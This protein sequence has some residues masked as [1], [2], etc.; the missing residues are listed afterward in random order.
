MAI[1]K[2][3][4]LVVIDM[5]RDFVPASIDNPDGGRFGVAEGQDVV[6]PICSMI[7]AASDVGAVILAS[8]DYHPNDHCSFS[9]YG[10][11]FPSHCVAGTSGAKFLPEISEALESAIKKN[12][13]ERV[14]IA[15]KGMHE[16]V[17]SFGALPYASEPFGDGRV[18]KAANAEPEGPGLGNFTKFGAIM[19]CTQA[20]WTGSLVLKQSAI[21]AAAD[22]TDGRGDDGIYDANAPPDVLAVLQDGVDRKLRNMQDAIAANICP[23]KGKIFVC[24][25]ALDFCVHD[26]C[27]NAVALGMER[28]FI[29]VD[30]AR[31]AHVPGVGAHGSGFLT[32]PSFVRS[33]L[34][35]N[36]VNMVSYWSVLPEGYA[37]SQVY[38]PGLG[39]PG[40]L[41]PIGLKTGSNLKVITV[42]I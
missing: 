13:P 31:A 24:G 36:G 12:G 10:G 35:S 5:Q 42:T 27:V 23:K 37:V 30:A 25:L 4:A 7:K 32:D 39:F 19:G 21:A 15:F 17:D 16:H 14:L 8:R 29:V 38:S 2:D 22:P 20:P 6:A 34:A 3:D 9:S 11:H 28:V 33:S 40:A 1:T 18:P 41:G 26:T